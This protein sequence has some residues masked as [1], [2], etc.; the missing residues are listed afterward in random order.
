MA[1]RGVAVWNPHASARAL[2][3][4]GSLLA[5]CEGPAGAYVPRPPPAVIE[6]SAAWRVVATWP[7]Q[8]DPAGGYGPY[9]ISPSGANILGDVAGRVHVLFGAV[10]GAGSPRF[11]P[12][13]V[14]IDASGRAPITSPGR[15]FGRGA[16]RVLDEETR[17]Y[18]WEGASFHR[19]RLRE[20]GAGVDE[21]DEVLF[22]GEAL[23]PSTDPGLS[24]SP[25]ANRALDVVVV[26]RYWN[27]LEPMLFARARG[28]AAGVNYLV[29]HRE[30]VLDRDINSGAHYSGLDPV[31]GVF[32][33]VDGPP[34]VLEVGNYASEGRASRAVL[35]AFATTV[36]A[37]ERGAGA[38]VLRRVAAVPVP[39]S[40]SSRV[41]AT[42]RRAWALV[43]AQASWSLY[44]FDRATEA[45]TLA[46]TIPAPLDLGSRDLIDPVVTDDGALYVGLRGETRVI[47]VTA[48][49]VTELWS[50]ELSR[51]EG[52]RFDALYSNGARVFAVVSSGYPM[53]YAARGRSPAQ[54]FTRPRFSLLTPNVPD[55]P[56]PPP[57]AP[58][59]F[60]PPPSCNPV[61]NEGCRSGEACDVGPSRTGFS[62]H[63]AGAAALCAACDPVAGPFCAPGLTCFT[64][65]SP[66]AGICVRL[67]CALADCGAIGAALCTPPAQFYAPGRL[68]VGVCQSTA[69]VDIFSPACAGI[70]AVAPSAGA[71]ATPP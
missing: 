9:P 1:H 21:Q 30:L 59:T 51:A 32:D 28:E 34:Y 27:N 35:Q 49:A 61:T 68:P 69:R 16:A 12:A 26:N 5:A 65:D 36:D 37:S 31:P 55:A 44:A 25:S 47:R 56:T 8:D 70:P 66:S 6:A 24:P 19:R 2:A 20:T 50:R 67:C 3:L 42:P 23:L 33:P 54:T 11:D 29:S 52:F 46:W 64:R 18:A 15:V 39:S 17:F 14:S 40:A 45:L 7:D 48:G 60:A 10:G 57:V 63:P 13:W 4:A 43:S 38:R 58:P 41:L 53:T 22:N 62:C 71:C